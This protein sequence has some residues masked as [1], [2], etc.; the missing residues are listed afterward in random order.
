M[1][2]NYFYFFQVVLGCRSYFPI[3]NL[4]KNVEVVSQ[5]NGHNLFTTYGNNFFFFAMYINIINYSRRT[6]YTVFIG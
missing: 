5:F 2:I 1:E 4:C 3:L 6:L